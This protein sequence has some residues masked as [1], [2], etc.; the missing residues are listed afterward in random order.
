M[1]T[2]TGSTI[3]DNRTDNPGHSGGSGGGIVNGGTMTIQDS[4]ISGNT[5]TGGV[6]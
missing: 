4:T 6:L 2:I 5:A 1:L 3:S